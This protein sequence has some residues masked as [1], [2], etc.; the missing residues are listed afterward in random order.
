MGGPGKLVSVD[1]STATGVGSWLGGVSIRCPVAD[2][3]WDN[4]RRIPVLLS[5]G[6]A[7]FR[8]SEAVAKEWRRGTGVSV[9]KSPR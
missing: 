8:S 1:G 9:A 6:E 2:V 3:G 7:P 5:G 4:C